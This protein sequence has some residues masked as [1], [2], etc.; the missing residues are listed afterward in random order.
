MTIENSNKLALTTDQKRIL[1]T[2]Q[3]ILTMTDI[4]E[5]KVQNNL[6]KKK[7]W[8][9]EWRMSIE[10]SLIE[11]KDNNNLQNDCG[12]FINSNSKL[13]KKIYHLKNDPEMKLPLYLIATEIILFRPYFSLGPEDTNN[14]YKNLKIS[15][16]GKIREKLKYILGLFNIDEEYID[17]VGKTEKRAIR[18]ITGYWEKVVCLGIG[19]VFVIATITGGL[20]TSS[21]F[22]W[23]INNG[24]SDF[25]TLVG[26]TIGDLT[27]ITWIF[28]FFGF[29]AGIGIGI[30]IVQLFR[31][32][33]NDILVN[34][35]KFEIVVREVLLYARKDIH[36]A[37]GLVDEQQKV[38]CSLKQ[39]LENLKK[40]KYENKEKIIILKETIVYLKKIVKRSNGFLKGNGWL[41]RNWQVREKFANKKRMEIIAA[42]DFATT[43]LNKIQQCVNAE[44]FK[45][46]TAN[47]KQR[48]WAKY[49]SVF[50]K[51]GIEG[52]I[53]GAATTPM[54]IR[55]IYNT[56]DNHE[57]VLN[58]LEYRFPREMGDASPLQWFGKVKD[59]FHGGKSSVGTYVSNYASQAGENAVVEDFKGQGINA[60]LFP[61]R[62]HKGTDVHEYHDD[63]TYTD[64]SVK[65]TESVSYLN[66][67]ISKDPETNHYVVNEELYSKLENSG[68]LQEYQEQGIE[69]QDGGF[70]NIDNREIANN[71]LEDI[72]DADDLTDDVPFVA[73]TLFGYKIVKNARQ[74]WA[75]K[76]SGCEFT[77]NTI[78][79]GV[80]ISI[81]GF[82]T[83]ICAQVGASVG[84]LFGPGVGTIIGGGIGAV[85]GMGLSSAVFQ[86]LKERWKWG[87]I[88]DAI[89]YFGNKYREMFTNRM[90][91]NIKNNILD[92]NIIIE[93]ISSEETLL[94]KFKDQ[95]DPYKEDK[96]TLPAI[97]CYLHYNDLKI[98]LCKI[99]KS[100][101]IAEGE[102][103]KLCKM[104]AKNAYKDV[105]KEERKEGE[106]RLLGEIIAANSDILLQDEMDNNEENMIAKYK[107][108]IAR[109][110][111]HPYR[112]SCDSKDILKGLFI[113]A[114][115]EYPVDEKLIE[116]QIFA[117]DK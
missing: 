99:E 93:K 88:I 107:N 43:D 70:S 5:E 10:Q 113:K 25:A 55:D 9:Y 31:Y 94:N 23:F 22:A 51:G 71:T 6:E 40:N 95:L 105:S 92:Q 86:W 17:E 14:L 49:K 56:C 102:I 106:K 69:I 58:V 39:K 7:K 30:S 3:Y 85:V 62:T 110:P 89:D 36:F 66:K 37:Q 80:R 114:M 27:L 15:A 46:N 104:V 52:G 32:S 28:I 18:G 101:Y 21:I 44:S 83:V 38:I 84:T 82:S 54:T 19:V 59:L 76:Q 64:Y 87:N 1:Y 90:R 78:V 42:I 8:L 109:S 34:F 47:S 61:S 50:L 2:C 16:Q 48:L 103:Y 20:S 63:G 60:E 91:M 65:S 57:E 68:K 115:I 97:L 67:S 96:V 13:E 29:G 24:F 74:V 116:E 45:V 33:L 72:N 4:Q 112:F 98:L 77:V 53:M 35:V 108:Q 26:S 41:Y 111:N 100:V 79:D 73:G 81:G 11:S 12:I 117:I 75:G